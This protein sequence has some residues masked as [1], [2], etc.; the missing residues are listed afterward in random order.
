[1]VLPN[2]VTGTEFLE[3]FA[4]YRPKQIIWPRPVVGLIDY[5]KARILKKNEHKFGL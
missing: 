2:K 1:M 4:T 5:Q 3:L